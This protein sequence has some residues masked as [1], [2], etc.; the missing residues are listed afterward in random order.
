METKV[1]TGMVR[2]RHLLD[3]ETKEETFYPYYYRGWSLPT[4]L[5]LYSPITILDQ[6][7]KQHYSIRY[8]SRPFART[9]SL[10][11][12]STPTGSTSL[13]RVRTNQKLAHRT[14]H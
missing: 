5:P 3:V 1:K 4:T 11:L 9:V 14:G 2:A 6:V 10:T 13:N 7:P 8:T 12:D